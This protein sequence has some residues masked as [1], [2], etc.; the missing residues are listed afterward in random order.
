M[1]SVLIVE[2][3]VLIAEYLKDTLHSLG[4]Y[5]VSLAYNKPQAIEHISACKPDLILLDVR[6]D[7]EYDGIAIA[8][9]IAEHEDIPFI[10]ISAHSD[11]EIL[12]MALRTKPE[13]YLTKPFKKMDVFAAVTLAIEAQKNKKRNFVFK[14]GYDTVVLDCSDILYLESDG[15]YVSIVTNEKRYTIRHSLDACLQQLPPDDFK[16]IHRSYIVN[17]SVV[18]KITS[19]SVVVEGKEIP[20][21]RSV[22]LGLE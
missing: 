17:L 21:S 9:Y 19:K 10:F 3:E 18:E 13:A 20:K 2:D 15:N 12:G 5:D 4:A 1:T 11:Q 7:K 6:L 14:D 16:R 8:E 22:N